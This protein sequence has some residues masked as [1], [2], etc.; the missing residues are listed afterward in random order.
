MGRALGGESRAH[1]EGLPIARLMGNG[2]RSGTLLHLRKRRHQVRPGPSLTQRESCTAAAVGRRARHQRVKRVHPTSTRETLA[3][4]L[5]LL[6]RYGLHGDALGQSDVPPHHQLHGIVHAGRSRQRASAE[7]VPFPRRSEP[8]AVKPLRGSRL[9]DPFPV[10][11]YGRAHR[12]CELARSARGLHPAVAAMPG[13][14]VQA[15]RSSSS[16]TSVTSPMRC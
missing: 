13:L 1:R 11:R 3:Y 12:S 4:L 14:G 5:Q 10:G 7:K 9:A 8:M 6:A 2:R 15:C 16:N